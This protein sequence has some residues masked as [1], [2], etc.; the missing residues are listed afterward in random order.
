M[1]QG[2][3]FVRERRNA[4]YDLWL[5]LPGLARENANCYCYGLDYFKGVEQ[6]LP[7]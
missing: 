7:L 3:C 4:T 2:T 5:K 1:Q 6:S